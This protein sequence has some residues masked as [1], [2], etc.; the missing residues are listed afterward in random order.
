MFAFVFLF[1]FWFLSL[2]ISRSGSRLLLFKNLHLNKKQWKNHY[3]LF[4][5]AYYMCV[6]CFFHFIKESIH[7]YMECYIESNLWMNESIC[8]HWFVSNV[9]TQ[10]TVCYLVYWT[11]IYKAIS[12]SLCISFSVILLFGAFLFH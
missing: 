7:T 8:R 12:F 1:L 5:V 11:R 6:C 4:Y 3:Y 2:F 10:Y 9:R